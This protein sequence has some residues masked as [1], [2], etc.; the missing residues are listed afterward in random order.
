MSVPAKPHV[1]QEHPIKDTTPLQIAGVLLL[2]VFCLSMASF[3]AG[4]A[5]WLLLAMGGAG[6][7]GFIYLLAAKLSEAFHPGSMRT[8]LVVGDTGFQVK[9]PWREPRHVSYSSIR[10]IMAR[11]GIKGD[12]EVVTALYVQ[13]DAGT[14]VLD[15]PL[16]QDTGLISHFTALPGFDRHAWCANA[17]D[18]S[19]WFKL[20]GRRSALLNRAS[21]GAG[22][23]K[24][25]QAPRHERKR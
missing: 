15:E 17:I 18:D 23:S 4:S 7:L 12:G 8:E 11:S 2:S 10:K 25:E 13:S 6:A 24:L 9:R 22:A 1:S 16:Y 21:V 19:L 20:W 5:V 3:K 14:F